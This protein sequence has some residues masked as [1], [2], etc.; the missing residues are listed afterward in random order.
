MSLIRLENV[1]KIYG[2]DTENPVHALDGVD[3]TIESGEFLAIIGASGSGKSTMMNILGCLDVPTSGEYFL[4]GIPIRQRRE[5]ELASI[6][7]RRIS[8]I[9]QGYNLIPSLKVWENVALP[10]VYQGIDKDERYNRAMAA[11]RRVEIASKA[12]SRP[13]QLSG[14]QQQRVAI[15]RAIATSSPLIMADEPTGALA[16]RTGAQVLKILKSLNSDG[17]TVILITHDNSI[18]MHAKRV[19]RM[20]DGKIISDRPAEELADTLIK[21]VAGA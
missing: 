10:M 2:A 13:S 14:G 7:S 6:R 16:S 12:D 1:Y 11:L 9:F 5:S 8:F 4:D 17:S 15:A 19:V 18:A 20:K 3:L 21:E